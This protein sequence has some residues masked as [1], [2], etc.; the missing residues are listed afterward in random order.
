M[1]NTERYCSKWLKF[2]I[3]IK[4]FFNKF[5]LLCSCHENR[6]LPLCISSQSFLMDEESNIPNHQTND[7]VPTEDLN[8][9]SPQHNNRESKLV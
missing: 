8:E 1:Y 5:Y 6:D 4:I 2:Q 9:F 7:N 3:F